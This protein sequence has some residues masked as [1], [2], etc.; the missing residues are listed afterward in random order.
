MSVHDR[1]SRKRCITEASPAAEAA[2]VATV[3]GAK[4]KTADEAEKLT[5]KLKD[6]LHLLL[7]KRG[8]DSSF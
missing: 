1:S 5:Q 7:E 6:T 3:T 8:P 4:N 2:I